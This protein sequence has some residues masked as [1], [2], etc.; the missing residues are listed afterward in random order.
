MEYPYIEKIKNGEWR[1]YQGPGKSQ[2]TM[3]SMQDGAQ[4]MMDYILRKQGKI[5][6]ETLEDA[7]RQSLE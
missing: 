6:S 3:H 4:R 5:P 7:V 2:Y 1:C